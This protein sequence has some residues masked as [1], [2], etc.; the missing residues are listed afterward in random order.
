MK[1]LIVLSSIIILGLIITVLIF[2]SS[3]SEDYNCDEFGVIYLKESE[4]QYASDIAND[5]N[6]IVVFP[7]PKFNQIIART[8]SLKCDNIDFSNYVRGIKE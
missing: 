1:K 4:L 6:G 5:I 3:P 8:E 2:V 7:D